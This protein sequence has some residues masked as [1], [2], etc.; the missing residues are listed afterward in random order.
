MI[1][2]PTTKEIKFAVF[3]LDPSKALGPDGSSTAFY[4]ACWDIVGMDVVKGIT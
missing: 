1:V 2:V 3:W 4:Q